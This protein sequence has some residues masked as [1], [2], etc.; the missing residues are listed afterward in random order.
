MHA[1]IKTASGKGN[2]AIGEV[3]EPVVGPTDVLIAVA[4]AG[5]CGTDLHIEEDAFH[6]D[7]PVVIG[8]E[9]AGRVLEVGEQVTN[10]QPGQRVVAEPHRGGCG[11]C[12]HCLTGA[13][14]VCAKKR[15]IGYRVDGCFQP[16]LVLPAAVIHRI[17]DAV[18]DEHAALTEPL[19][20]VVKAVLQRS[21]VESQDVVA[22]LGCGPIGL[23]A[24]AAARAGGARRVMITGTERDEA[25]R[26][27]AAR[28]MGFE[29]VINIQRQDPVARIMD[30]TNGVG[31]DLVVEATGV[32]AAIAQG[33]RMLRIDGRFCGLGISGREHIAI[34][35]DA[36]LKKAANISFS[37]SSNFMAWE[38]AL[39]LMATGKVD[40]G[41]IITQRFPLA[42]W[43]E[44]F[45]R[46]RRLE[47]I[48]V[49]LT[50][51]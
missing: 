44:A 47:A 4:C 28:A 39:S 3:R 10:V 21:R 40:P 7:P 16:R 9:F 34:P 6:Y 37:Y 5:I 19:A 26:L 42:E 49:L 46:L 30:L 13:V 29:T 48:K 24:A 22:V 41:P 2:L 12:R 51:D 20:V 15:A 1:L 45:D 25:V 36:A 31:A 17:P 8:H 43:R 50:F 18:S 14:E 33:I 35:W 32:E 27:A 38:R 23:L 11:V